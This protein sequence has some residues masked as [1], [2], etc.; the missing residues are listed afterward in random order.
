MTMRTGLLKTHVQQEHARNAIPREYLENISGRDIYFEFE[1]SSRGT[2][3]FRTTMV[4]DERIEERPTVDG[5][6][7]YRASMSAAL[8]SALPKGG[9]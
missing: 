1:E 6:A 7:V 9:D 5:F 8:L 2:G 4:I 3:V